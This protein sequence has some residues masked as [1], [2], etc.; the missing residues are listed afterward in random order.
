MKKIIKSIL[1]KLITTHRF[2]SIVN[3]FTPVAI[4]AGIKFYGLFQ[5]PHNRGETLLSKEP[6]MISFI[7]DYVQD[8]D[9]YYDIG[10]NIGVFSMYSAIKKNARVFS[11]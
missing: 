4:N 6:D 11:F 5:I 9:I 8:G 7:E 2:F 1:R 10:A 3:N